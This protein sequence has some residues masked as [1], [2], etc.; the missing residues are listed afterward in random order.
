MLWITPELCLAGGRSLVVMEYLDVNQ[1]W[2]SFDDATLH[3]EV[4]SLYDLMTKALSS[5][6]A[7]EPCCARGHLRDANLRVRWYAPL[8]CLQECTIYQRLW[9]GLLH[10][11]PAAYICQPGCIV[12]TVLLL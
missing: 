2:I 1:G 10:L 8:A 7:H 3:P 4:G 9:A 12:R 6:H 11:D 5:A